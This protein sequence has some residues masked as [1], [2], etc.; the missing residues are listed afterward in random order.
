[1]R[2]IDACA[3]RAREAL[4]TM[5]DVARFRLGDGPL[6]GR[7][8]AL[9]HELAEAAG[10]VPGGAAVLAAWRDTPRDVGTSL[11]T[12]S[13]GRRSGMREV[14]IAAARRAAEGLRTLEE[15][16]KTFDQPSDLWRVFESIRYRL[17]DCERSLTLAFGADGAPQWRLCVLITE[18]LCRRPWGEVVRGAIL[19]GADCLQ[20]REPEV[21]DRL[22]LEHAAAARVIIDEASAELDRR[23]ALIINNRVDVALVARADGVHLGV[24][25]LPIA[26]ARR[27]AGDRLL[28]GASTHNLEEAHLAAEAGADYCGVGAM[29]PTATKDRP[30]SGTAYLRAFIEAFPALPHLAIGGITNENAPALVAAGARGIAVSSAVCGSDDP[31]RACESLLA[32][33]D[34]ATEAD[35]SIRSR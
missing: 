8:K 7:L 32:A 27:L 28:I 15:T 29:F 1:M 5:E 22:L 26:E 23:P 4:R 10:R 14:A 18:Q 12:G 6:C 21:P 13:E 33:F 2:I 34:A 9:R 31:R 24:D 3:N 17:Y 35:Q 25:D 20:I 16:A 30:P 19:G 11:K